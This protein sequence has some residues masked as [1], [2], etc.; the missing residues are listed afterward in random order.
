MLTRFLFVLIYSISIFHCSKEN[1]NQREVSKN[2]S[3]KLS[4]KASPEKKEHLLDMQ[5]DLFNGEEINSLFAS[6]SSKSD[7]VCSMVYGQK[8]FDQEFIKEFIN[9]NSFTKPPFKSWG[10]PIPKL[11]AG[12]WN[13]FKLNDTRPDLDIHLVN[14]LYPNSRKECFSVGYLQPYLMHSILNCEKLTT[15]DMDWRIAYGHKQLYDL[16]KSNKMKTNTE[17]ESSV[18]SLDLHWI[19]RFDNKPMEK[20]SK[21]EFISVCY[22]QF[23][24]TCY[25]FLSKFQD[26][27]DKIQEFNLLVASLHEPDYKFTKGV[28]PVFFLSNATEDFYTS[29]SEFDRMMKSVNSG[30]SENEKAIFIHHAAGRALFGIYEFTKVSNTEFSIESKCRDNFLSSPVGN[31]F[32]PYLTYFDKLSKNHK[33]APKC[34]G[35]ELIKE[36]L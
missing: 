10:S 8:K 16:F 11:I 12:C 14:K 5:K 1:L 2:D 9:P 27:F 26:S 21:L 34:S 23:I 7:E 19:A 33:T 24:P 6:M 4:L 32:H 35:N 17:I 30:L 29:Q 15:I 31:D 13:F 25:K 36:F 18:K 28:T 20:K 22:S 3:P